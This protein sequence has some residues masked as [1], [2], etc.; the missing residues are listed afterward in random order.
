MKTFVVVIDG[1][2]HTVRVDGQGSVSVDGG[3]WK[4]VEPTTKLSDSLDH[5]Y[6]LVVDGVSAAEHMVAVR[7]S[8][9][10]DNVAV[11]KVLVR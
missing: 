10:Y 2:D 4:V 5:G 7:V 1:R 9:E 6:V 3:E 11:E 8:D